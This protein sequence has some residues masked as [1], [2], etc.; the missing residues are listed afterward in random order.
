MFSSFTGVLPTFLNKQSISSQLHAIK[1]PYVLENGRCRS[2]ET[3][4]PFKTIWIFKYVTHWSRTSKLSSF[5]KLSWIMRRIKNLE[6]P[7]SC[8]AYILAQHYVS[9]MR[10]TYRNSQDLIA[11]RE[12]LKPLRS[13]LFRMFPSIFGSKE[14]KKQ[15]SLTSM[16]CESFSVDLHFFFFPNRLQRVLSVTS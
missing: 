5:E 16:P 11:H 7:Q 9:F 14:N 12:H 2:A 3:D 15:T 4:L 13:F 8:K 10:K 1:P 6:G